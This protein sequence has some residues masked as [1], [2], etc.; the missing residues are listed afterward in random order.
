MKGMA[1]VKSAG[2]YA[3]V[4]IVIAVAFLLLLLLSQDR[5]CAWQVQKGTPVI[6]LHV[7]AAGDSPEEQSFKMALVSRVQEHLA[8]R[9]LSQSG[10]CSTYLDSLRASL[11]G[12]REEMLRFADGAGEEGAIAVEL[13]QEYF[14]LRTYGRRIYPAGRYTALV[15]TVGEGS[16]ENWWCL[17]FPPLCLPP[18]T[19]SD[20]KVIPD[21]YRSTP[22]GGGSS[23]DDN[24]PSGKEETEGAIRWR[25]AFW[26]L[27]RRPG[28]YIVEKVEEIFYN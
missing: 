13:G 2:R 20:D 9:A 6:R 14:P 21:A 26:E 25:S 5:R 28:Q 15:I 19:E 23:A 4:L 27:I 24:A 8:G 10:D 16:G 18:V 22:T 17:L 11:P 1:T 7:R 3:A 12:L